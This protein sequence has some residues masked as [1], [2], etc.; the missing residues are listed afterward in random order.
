MLLRERLPNLIA[1]ATT[2][3]SPLQIIFDKSNPHNRFWERVPPKDKDGSPLSGVVWEY[4][5]KVMN[6]SARTIKNVRLSIEGLGLLPKAP[7]ELAFDKDKTLIRDLQPNCYEFITFLWKTPHKTRDAWGR[8]ATELHGPIKLVASGDD[9]LPAECEFDYHPDQTPIDVQRRPVMSAVVV[10]SGLQ[11][12][13]GDE[14]KAASGLY[15]VTHTY[16]IL[17]KNVNNDYLSNCKLFL[18]I[19]DASGHHPKNYLMHI[20]PFTLNAAE[21]R[22]FKIV[23]YDEPDPKKITKYKGDVIRLHI[24]A[25]AGYY[26][27]GYGWPWRLP[28][29]KQYVFTLRATTKDS[30]PAETVCRTWVDDEGKLHL[31]AA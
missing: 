10:S 12:V 9:V 17:V 13:F 8:T 14:D 20:E 31:E 6:A 24:P 21:D 19:S 1:M 4:R 29:D 22:S 15:K 18:V 27:V 26:D 11:I 16:S 7:V 28:A 2:P 25:V 3:L 5:V 23:S 30:P